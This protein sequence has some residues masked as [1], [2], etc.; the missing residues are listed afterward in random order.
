MLSQP[1]SGFSSF[2]ATI[3]VSGTAQ[4]GSDV[5][6]FVN[7]KATG[8]VIVAGSDGHFTT[9]VTLT[10]GSN[11]IQATATDQYGTGPASAVVLVTLDQTIPSSPGSLTATAQAAG[12]V[13]LGWTRS[14]DPN[15]VGYDLYRSATAFDSIAEA[16]NV[17]TSM[18]I[19]TSF[20]D[21]PPQDG[22][23]VYRVV[24]V[25]AAG[26][27]STPSNLAQ[28]VSDST[29]PRALSIVY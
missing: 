3:A 7:A 4:P 21:M 29:A 13:R 16:T 10:T 8:P 6:L 27:S 24:T 12:K 28:V 1:V 14:T 18:L 25:N 5:Q 22:S 19:V 17:N 20:D 9:S 15:A 11:Q 26:T 2:T 23:W